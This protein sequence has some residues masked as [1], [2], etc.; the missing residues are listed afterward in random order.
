MLSVTVYGAD[1]AKFDGV[2]LRAGDFRLLRSR[3]T[4][5]K[6]KIIAELQVLERLAV[7]ETAGV[8]KARAYSSAIKTIKTWPPIRSLEDVPAAAKGDGIGK[9]IR[10]KIGKIIENGELDIDPEARMRAHCFEAF[11]GIYGVG[12]KKAEDLIAMGMRSIA[13]VRAALAAN[14]KLLNRNQQVGLRYYEDIQERI[15]R[16]EMDAHA[17][18]LMSLK[19][20]ALEGTIVGSYRRG[21]ADSGDID[22]LVRTASAEVDAGEALRLYVAAL[23]DAGYIRE[24]LAQGDTKCLAVACVPGGKMRR[25]DLLVTPPSQFPFAVFYFTGS[26]L[27]NV[28][29]RQRALDRGFTLNEHALTHLKTNRAVDGIRTERDI[30]AALRMAWKEP[31]ERTGPEAVI[32]VE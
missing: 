21:A 25:L 2:R 28:A 30:F 14:P 13:D 24:V 18:L 10:V 32:S 6:S 22:M 4:D 27:F 1:T 23:Q 7:A 31:V 26:D 19:P 3:M 15:P 29:V 11:Q 12:P 5:F 8:F 16:A 9:E 20:A 17:A